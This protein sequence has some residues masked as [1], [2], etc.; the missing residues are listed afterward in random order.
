LLV[1]E[2]YDGD[3]V[4]FIIDVAYKDSPIIPMYSPE[5]YSIRD[6]YEHVSERINHIKLLANKVRYSLDSVFNIF[7]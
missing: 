3:W 4:I 2:P 5:Q 7:Y 6:F 1:V